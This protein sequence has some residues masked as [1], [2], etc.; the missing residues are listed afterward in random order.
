MKIIRLKFC[1]DKGKR[2]DQGR[3]SCIKHQGSWQLLSFSAL[4]LVQLTVMP[5]FLDV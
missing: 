4:M 5:Q 1:L 2:V 3:R